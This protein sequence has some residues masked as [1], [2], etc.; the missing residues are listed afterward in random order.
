MTSFTASRKVKKAEQL[1]DT[2]ARRSRSSI[3]R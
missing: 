2:A 1:K 3:G